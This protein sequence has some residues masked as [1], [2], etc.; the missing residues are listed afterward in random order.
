[1]A[2]GKQGQPQNHGQGQ[3]QRPTSN[4]GPRNG[5]ASSG[6]GHS[7]ADQLG[8]AADGLQEG[9]SQVGQHLSAGYEQARQSV[10]AGVRGARGM[11]SR[12]PI[13]SVLVGF[14]LGLGVGV[15][16]TTL[17]NQR[18]SHWYDDYVPDRMRHVPDSLRQVGNSMRDIAE[19]LRQH[20]PES[21]A[22]HLSA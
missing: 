13:P 22:R 10:S 16:L 7:I 4:V 20:V 6:A 17:L 14:G 5:G 11:V 3:P 8:T 1:M 21:V 18:E 19:R 2:T 9:A 15:L 12:N